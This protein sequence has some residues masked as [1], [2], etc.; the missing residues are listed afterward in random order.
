MKR[1]AAR[2]AFTDLFD[3]LGI[4]RDHT[5]I[6][7]FLKSCISGRC[8]RNDRVM[9]DRVGFHA[10]RPDIPGGKVAVVPAVVIAVVAFLLTEEVQV[11]VKGEIREGL[12]HSL[13]I[14]KFR[15]Q[16][17]APVPLAVAEILKRPLPF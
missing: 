9:L 3:R 13:A 4:R 7:R 16:A 5:R 10:Q 8:A 2:L 1:Q 14:L 15:Q 11:L 17:S 6:Q 12:F